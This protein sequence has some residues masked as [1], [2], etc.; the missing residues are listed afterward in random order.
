MA[1]YPH[2]EVKMLHEKS[3]YLYLL[4]VTY[5][6]RCKLISIKQEM[7]ICQNLLSIILFLCLMYFV[8]AYILAVIY[9]KIP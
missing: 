2:N 4:Y 8:T 3:Y 9:E 1:S 6:I 5:L 7:G